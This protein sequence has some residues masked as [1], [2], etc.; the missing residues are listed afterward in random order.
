MIKGTDAYGRP[1]EEII[2]VRKTSPLWQRVLC[3]ILP[4]N[5]AYRLGL[6]TFR[7]IKSVI[8]VNRE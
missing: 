1:I 5:M 6:T 4:Q 8:V 2:N 3:F 7:K